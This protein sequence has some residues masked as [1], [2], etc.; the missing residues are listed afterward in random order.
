MT[1]PFKVISSA[2]FKTRNHFVE[3]QQVSLFRRE[4]SHVLTKEEVKGE[5]SKGRF[6][7]TQI[8]EAK[9]RA[10]DK[11]ADRR[12]GRKEHFNRADGRSSLFAECLIQKSHLSNVKTQRLAEAVWCSGEDVRFVI[13][14][15]GLESRL[16]QV[17]ISCASE[18]K[19]RG[20]RH[21]L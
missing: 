16:G 15:P 10:R 8:H 20:D 6:S 4:R 11:Y 1:K 13:Y 3:Q 21:P 2:N 19:L 17:P 18:T 7:T 5:E 12:K 14:I 9:K